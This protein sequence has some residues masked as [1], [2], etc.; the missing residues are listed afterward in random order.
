MKHTELKV[1]RFLC[2]ECKGTGETGHELGCHSKDMEEVK[3]STPVRAIAHGLNY[4]EM[5]RIMFPNGEDSQ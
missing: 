3:F 5:M 4:E 1:R 2:R